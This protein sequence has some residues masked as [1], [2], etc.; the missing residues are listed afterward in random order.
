M[1]GKNLRI[2][3]VRGAAA[4][5]VVLHHAAKDF[6]L[7]GVHVGA[8]FAFGQEAVIVFFVL[9]GFTINEAFSKRPNQSFR[10][11]LRRRLTRIYIPLLCTFV[12]FYMT[13][14]IL[15]H[16]LVDP[17]L[18]S[19]LANV[20]ML[21]DIASLKPGVIATPYLDDHPLWSLSYEWW[22]YMLFYPIVR[23]IPKGMQT[24]TVIGVGAIAAAMYTLTPN[25]PMRVLAYM[26]IWWAG[27]LLS[28]HKAESSS[29]SIFVAAIPLTIG[30]IL[31]LGLF[32]EIH[33]FAHPGIH[34]LLE[35][36]HFLDASALIL[37]YVTWKKLNW[38]G[39]NALLM[40]FT[41]LAP[42]SYG[43][44]I[45]HVA[46]ISLADR[47]IDNRIMSVLVT[48]ALSLVFAWVI[49]KKIYVMAE[50]RIKRI[51]PD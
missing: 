44:Y 5:Y 46:G 38:I 25:F 50:T 32:N 14:S 7:G 13:R 36:R 26:C 22:F 35:I 24:K 51:F 23:F 20:A 19:L 49:E 41:A 42:I 31:T 34:P 12:L 8:L 2:E 17:E 6:H 4:L 30:L 45:A 37:L 11:Y 9:S 47:F 33:G 3:A 1:Q 39:F 16:H 28:R 29:N 21:Q 48:L 18:C 27:V 10:D 15:A 43:L 40:P